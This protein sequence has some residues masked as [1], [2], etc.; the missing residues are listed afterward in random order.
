MLVC[1]RPAKA[2]L[3][4]VKSQ[5]ATLS[6]TVIEGD[7]VPP[8]YTSVVP[9]SPAVPVPRSTVS[10]TATGAGLLATEASGTDGSFT[11]KDDTGATGLRV[12][13]DNADSTISLQA[14]SPTVGADGAA[15]PPRTGWW[16]SP[17][18]PGGT[19]KAGQAA[20]AP[21]VPMVKK[22]TASLSGKV[23]SAETGG[24]L[25]NIKLTVRPTNSGVSDSATVTTDAAGVYSIPAMLFGVNNKP[26]TFR[27]TYTNSL[28][29]SFPFDSPQASCG[30]AVTRDFQL[31]LIPPTQYGSVAGRV[32]DAETGL[33]VSGVTVKLSTCAPRVASE[34]VSV[35]SGTDGRYTI[36]QIPIGAD[37]AG[38]L[39]GTLNTTFPSTPPPAYWPTSATTTVKV[40]S[41]TA[42]PDLQ[43]PQASIR[44]RYRRRDR[45]GDEVAAQG[46]HHDELRRAAGGM[47]PTV[48]HQ[49]RG[50]LFVH[51]LGSQHEQ[52][53]SQRNDLGAPSPAT[54]TSPPS[55]RC[56]R[57]RQRRQASRW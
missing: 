11:V 2:T 16:P 29:Q 42:V 12:N 31:A 6:G 45:L 35:P 50:Q 51:V 28:N 40:G 56:Q 3:A 10:I 54:G 20:T 53:E 41:P 27:V 38:S 13:P 7:P 30:T 14:A 9:K 25:P 21:A 26:G 4:L 19:L 32:V 52:R 37:P 43:V 49:R 8:A 17:A 15:L 33:P 18:V 1:N 48:R 24:A 46:R 44:R 47:R 57:A 39:N 36:G 34:C 23:T 22:C 55:Q 5:A